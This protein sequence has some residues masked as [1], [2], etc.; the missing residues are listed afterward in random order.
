[1]P[2]A[3]NLQHP[4]PVVISQLIRA[5]APQ[6][7]DYR[8]LLQSVKGTPERGPDITCPGQVKWNAKDAVEVEIEGVVQRADGYVLFR[9]DQLRAAGITQLNVNDII[10]SMGYGPNKQTAQLYIIR[11]EP[12]GHYGDAGGATLMKAWFKDRAPARPT[13]GG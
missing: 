11:L 1:M 12:M 2:H 13:H 7:N 4:V 3:P 5:A 10:R 6:D 8:E 9:T